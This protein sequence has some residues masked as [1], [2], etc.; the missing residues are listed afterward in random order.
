MIASEQ[1]VQCELV[2]TEFDQEECIPHIQTEEQIRKAKLEPKIVHE[3]EP[4]LVKFYDR[5][6]QQKARSNLESAKTH[7]DSSKL[8]ISFNR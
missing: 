7:F 1:C 5:A 2:I 6:A 8:R 3:T 4:L